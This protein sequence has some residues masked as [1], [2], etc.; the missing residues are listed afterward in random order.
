MKYLLIIFSIVTVLLSGCG[1][2]TTQ[3]TSQQPCER[4]NSPYQGSWLLTIT[5]DTTASDT[6]HVNSG[7]D[8]SLDSIRMKR[9]GAPY[10]TGW[11]F[12][13]FICNNGSFE[14][15]NI[16]DYAIGIIGISYCC[17]K[18]TLT[19]GIN[20][21]NINAAFYYC[22]YIPGESCTPVSI[23]DVTGTYNNNSATGSF[24]SPQ[25]S[26]SWSITKIN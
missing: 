16:D 7:G 15:G 22:Y 19:G 12:N 18:Q 20:G 4:T 24:T 5:S 11:G 23:G 14:T 17:H 21:S 6:I 9:P 13:G 10:C 3:T 25:Y 8:A 1:D 26:G 2:D